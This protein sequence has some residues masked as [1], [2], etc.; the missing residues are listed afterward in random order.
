ML[1]WEFPRPALNL[2]APSVVTT[3]LIQ[4]KKSLLI[5]DRCLLSLR[6]DL[7]FTKNLSA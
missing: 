6:D 3:D 5:Q 4:P 7:E 1:S 2:K